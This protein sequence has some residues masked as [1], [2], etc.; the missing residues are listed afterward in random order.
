MP[1]EEPES[2]DPHELVGVA[3]PGDEAS[4][5]EM[6]VTFAEELAQLGKSREQILGLFR[7][8]FY[9]GAHGV[10]EALGEEEIGRIVDESIELFGGF[11][12][13][14]TEPVESG[15]KAPKLRRLRVV[16]R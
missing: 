3:L 4:T 16:G 9:A 11:R 15:E 8:P 14:V 12:V 7:D 1:Y 13:S 5:R 10:L 6:A 2:D